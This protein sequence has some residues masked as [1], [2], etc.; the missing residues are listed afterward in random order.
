MPTENLASVV[1]NRLFRVPDYQRGYAWEV[2]QL[3][4]FWKDLTWLRPGQKHYTGALTLE[5]VTKQLSGFPENSPHSLFHIV[6]GQQRLTTTYLLLHKLVNRAVNGRIGGQSVVIAVNNYIATSIDDQDYAIFGYN[7]PDKMIFLQGLL[8][9]PPRNLNPKNVYEKRLFDASSFLNEKLKGLNLEQI[10]V[11]FNKLTTQLVFDIHIVENGFDACAMFE[12]INYRGK[13]LSEFEVLKNRLMYLTELI[14]QAE[15]DKQEECKL[16]RKKIESAWGEA[17]DWLGY[18]VDPLDEDEF[19]S[20]HTIMYFGAIGHGKNA[21]DSRLF[22]EEFSIDRLT[23]QKDPVDLK[24]LESYI[25]DITTS[26]MLWA[27]QHSTMPGLP[28]QPEWVTKDIVDWLLRL[29]RLGMR[30]FEPMIL[31]ALN[32]IFR[33]ESNETSQSLVSLLKEIE[34]FIFIMY[35]LCDYAAHQESKTTFGEYANNIHKNLDG[36]EFSLIADKLRN[37]LYSL[38]DENEMIG[39]VKTSND[40]AGVVKARFLRS[41]GWRSWDAIKYFLSE[42]E[43]HLDKPECRIISQDHFASFSVEHI[44]NQQPSANGQWMAE[45]KRLKKR[46]DF[47]VHDLGNLVLLGP[48]AN[49][50]VNDVDLKV[51]KDAYETSVGSK[52]VLR[53]AGRRFQWDERKILQRGVAMI[54]FLIDRWDLPGQV[55]N[56]DYIIHANDM[57]SKDVKPPK[58]PRNQM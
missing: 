43:S 46:F 23:D 19:L 48:G 31:A 17:F 4:D 41:K 57:L 25:N 8:S 6:D 49:K 47:V 39:H 13:K 54:T 45:S 53:R 33:E 26:A 37:Y 58:Q 27:F 15:P 9:G 32:R 55:K 22:K 2:T 50:A 34:R 36:F 18:G 29:K 56:G 5:P 3:E 38:N 14:R 20:S 35:E 51:K 30:H 1:N 7:A 24:A 16:L 42:W 40:I 44:M 10:D 52:D 11:V 12:S 21:L 28:S